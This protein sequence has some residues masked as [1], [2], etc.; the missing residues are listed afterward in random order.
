LPR[1]LEVVSRR[2]ITAE[3]GFKMEPGFRNLDHAPAGQ[4][5][6]HDR[7]GEIRAPTDGMII[8]PLY[9]GLG[10]DG[11]FWGRIVSDA[12]MKTSKALRRL[13]LDRL[14]GLLPGVARD[15]ER[16][17]RFIVNTRVAAL[18]PLDVFHLFG[19]RRVRQNGA[20]MTVERQESRPA[21][22]VRRGE[23]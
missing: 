15:P 19:Y 21:G 22:S 16:P 11:F 10:S 12:R 6:A 13:G 17:S 8:L 7:N 23:S 3:D 4:L 18:Y 2:A 20:K 5:L 1:V 14:L 9:Q